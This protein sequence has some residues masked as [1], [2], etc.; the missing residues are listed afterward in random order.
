MGSLLQRPGVSAAE[1]RLVIARHPQPVSKREMRAT[2]PRLPPSALCRQNWAEVRRIFDVGS[3]PGVAACEL[4]RHFA[5]ATVAA[6]DGSE[7]LLEKAAA[8]AEAVGLSCRV[9]ARK[10]DMPG[11]V[12]SLGPAD[13][14]KHSI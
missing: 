9:T 7:A 2:V 10:V 12:E 11:G 3:G 14:W 5:S 4:A 8:P 6:V 13:R 1:L